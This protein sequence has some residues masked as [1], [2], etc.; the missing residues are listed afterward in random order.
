MTIIIYYSSL[1]KITHVLYLLSKKQ[2]LSIIIIAHLGQYLTDETTRK[3]HSTTRLHHANLKSDLDEALLEAEC[4]QLLR[5]KAVRNSLQARRISEENGDCMVAYWWRFQTLIWWPATSWWLVQSSSNQ[6]QPAPMCISHLRLQDSLFLDCA[7]P[8]TNIELVNS[9]Q[10]RINHS[11][12]LQPPPRSTRKSMAQKATNHGCLFW[13]P[14]AAAQWK[15]VNDS[16]QN[17]NKAS[18]LRAQ[19]WKKHQNTMEQ[20]T[21]TTKEQKHEHEG[22]PDPCIDGSGDPASTMSSMSMF[23]YP[24]SPFNSSSVPW[25]KVCLFSFITQRPWIILWA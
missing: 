12:T 1:C 23:A 20:V 9:A 2:S 13:V 11:F 5:W 18:G 6:S 25:P 4:H 19:G 3:K 14:P 7:W 10:L 22:V 16:E 24:K 15:A 8:K 17:R 21:S